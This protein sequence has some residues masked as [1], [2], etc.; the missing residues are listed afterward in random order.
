M[1]NSTISNNSAGLNG[2]GVAHSNGASASTTLTNTTISGNSA[3]S[4][5]GIFST[6]SSIFIINNATISENTSTTGGGIFL[7]ST[8]NDTTIDNSI[9]AG[10][11][12]SS[13][14]NEIRAVS[15]ST[16]S[17][18]MVTNS[19]LG[20]NSQ[21]PSE[22]FSVFSPDAT[23]N[24]IAT[25]SGNNPTG[26][27]NI[28]APLSDNGGDTLTHNLVNNSPAIDAGDSI[29]CPATDQRGENRDDNC[30]IGAVEFDSNAD[31][32]FFVVPLPNGT[33]VIF[34]L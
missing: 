27:R 12:S 14:G 19:I 6:G 11:T 24:F 10:N 17:N 30:N 16:T 23:S 18:V 13:L 33:T 32:T 31:I 20:D 22:A 2:G 1:S 28:I 15:S 26:L 8:N 34:G 5:G 9:I 25:L 29:N 3:S 7:S 4:G 21:T